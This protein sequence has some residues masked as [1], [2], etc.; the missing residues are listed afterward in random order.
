MLFWKK[1]KELF[2]LL[3]AAD[4]YIVSQSSRTLNSIANVL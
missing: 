1:D 4:E 2:K 3:T